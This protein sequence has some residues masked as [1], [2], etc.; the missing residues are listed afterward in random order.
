MSSFVQGAVLGFSIAAPVGP[1][2]LL[3]IRRAVTDGR[4]AGFVSGLGAATADTLYGLVAATGLSVVT[5][6]MVAHRVWFQVAG[7]AFLAWLGWRIVRT[8][9]PVAPAAAGAAPNLAAAFGS[10]FVLTALNPMTIV[11]F[12]GAFAG[13]AVRAEASRGAAFWLVA[14][15]FVGSSL[16]WLI[17]SLLAGGL[18]DRLRPALLHRVNVAAGAVVAGFGL[19]LLATLGR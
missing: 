15:V 17:L 3:C 18:R 5:E 8:S 12:F 16:W 13:L 11:A 2:G 6:F 9:T 7:G 10:T 19:W 14:G 4:L 1:I